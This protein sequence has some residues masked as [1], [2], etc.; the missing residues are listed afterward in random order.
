[1]LKASHRF[2]ELAWKLNLE[3]ARRSKLLCGFHFLQ[4]CDTNRYENSNGIVDCFDDQKGISESEF[5]KFNGDTVLLADLPKRVF[6]QGET[7]TTPAIVSHFSAELSGTMTFAFKLV[8]N[9]GKTVLNG[10]LSEVN[11]SDKGRHD[12]CVVTCKMPITNKPEA[13]KL[14]FSLLDTTGKTVVE[15]DW[16]LWSFPNHPSTMPNYEVDVRLDSVFPLNRYPQL[17]QHN[18]AKLLLANRFS[19]EL[20]EH[21]SNGG[22]AWVMY[23]VPVTRDRKVRAPKEKYYLPAVWDRFKAIIWDRGHNSGAFIR[24]NSVLAG[25]PN[26]GFVNM[27]FA[28][29]INDCD[30]IILD[31]FP[32]HVEP[33][34][35]G[36]DRAVRDRFDVYNFK[37]SE[38]QPAYTMRKFAYLFELRVGKGRLFVS[39]FNFTGLNQDDPESVGMFESILRYLNSDEFAPATTIEAQVLAD[40]L[41]RKG[42]GPIIKERRM[43]QYWQLDEEPLESL[44][45]WNEALAYIDEE[46]K[47][48]DIWLKAQANKLSLDEKD[49]K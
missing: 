5:R 23:R 4:F 31:D 29:L 45:Y 7:V 10:T 24:A 32:V 36:V 40:Y 39:A 30:K 1:M 6:F 34:M 16:G 25:F 28:N 33:I 12:L 44:K 17:R 49:K 27:Q 18:G 43:T 3:A 19:Q 21:V 11:L 37:L 46:V 8:D 48:T 47:E 22:D 14:V 13:Y 35:E 2:R 38:L 9:G 41:L 20:I 42:E 15:N 26:D